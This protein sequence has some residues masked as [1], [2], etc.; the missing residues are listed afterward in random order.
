VS[1]NFPFGLLPSGKLCRT[2]ALRIQLRSRARAY[3]LYARSKPRLES[4]C[5]ARGIPQAHCNVSG[6]RCI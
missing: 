2:A 6:S 3:I 1:G 4:L 5:G